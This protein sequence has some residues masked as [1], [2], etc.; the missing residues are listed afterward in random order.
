MEKKHTAIEKISSKELSLKLE[1]DL[2]IQRDGQC[3]GYFKICS[4]TFSTQVT[5]YENHR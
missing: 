4:S 3:G 5:L 2:K 1:L